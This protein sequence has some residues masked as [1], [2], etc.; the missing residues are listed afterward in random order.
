MD[1]DLDMQTMHQYDYVKECHKKTGESCKGFEEYIKVDQLA[2][3]Y[4]PMQHLCNF[5]SAKEALRKGTIFPELYRP[6]GKN[7]WH[8]KEVTPYVQ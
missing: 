8:C 1:S 2:F 3:A 7:A 6:Y 4:V 5:F